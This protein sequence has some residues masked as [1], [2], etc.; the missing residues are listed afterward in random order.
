MGVEA[1]EGGVEGGRQRRRHHVRLGPHQHLGGR[2]VSER[3]RGREQS[4]RGRVGRASVPGVV[5]R[6]WEEREVV[7]VG[8]RGLLLGMAGEAGAQGQWSRR[9]LE[10]GGLLQEAGHIGGDVGWDGPNGP[11]VGGRG[12]RAV[13]R[14]PGEGRTGIL[15]RVSRDRFQARLGRRFGGG[16]SG[17]W[18]RSSRCMLDVRAGA[19]GGSPGG[20]L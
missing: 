18:G 10:E 6:G 5:G 16:W 1:G 12:G 13:E 20:G 15:G 2:G 11:D 3:G 14:G 9:G 4:G 7:G 17:V 19:L 8:E